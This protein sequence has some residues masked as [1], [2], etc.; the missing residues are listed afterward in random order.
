[1]TTATAPPADP[2]KLPA[3]A[4]YSPQED[5]PLGGYAT[6]VGIFGAS[7]AGGLAAAHASGRELP[8]R[9]PAG[10]LA[11][12]ALAVARVSRIATRDIVTSWIRAPFM[13]FVEEAG[14]GEVEETA[15]G[16]GMRRAV[17]EMLNCP[18]CF[19]QWVAGAFTVGWVA[20]PKLTRVLAGMWAAQTLADV[21]NMAYAKLAEEV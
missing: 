15:R 18:Y 13:R 8:D 14:H 19:S 9:I 20:S 21:G 1:M 7:L 17:G 2:T 16:T 10:D 6:L 5:R 3:G 11:I 4:G 12:T